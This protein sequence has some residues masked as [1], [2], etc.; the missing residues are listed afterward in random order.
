MAADRVMTL[1]SVTGRSPVPLDEV[2]EVSTCL[3]RSPVGSLSCRT[4][5]ASHAGR[6]GNDAFVT[7][8][9]DRRCEL[10]PHQGALVA[11]AYLRKHDALAQIA[12]GF[13]ISVGTAHATAVVRL[14]AYWTPGLLR[15]LRENDPDYVLLDGTSASATTW[16]TDPP[17]TPTSIGATA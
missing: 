12:A 14:L 13:G 1:V 15:T 4:R 11:H 16:A 9:G 10:P 5:P 3:L 7:R 2:F 6:V 8:E 17:T